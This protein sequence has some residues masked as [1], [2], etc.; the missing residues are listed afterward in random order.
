MT[1]KTMDLF[2]NA[3][4]IRLDI[5]CGENKQPGGFLGMDKLDLPGVDIVH[6]MET[7]PW[8]IPDNSV[9][10]AIASHV[11]EHID[12]AHGTFL[13][14]MDEVWRIL[15]PGC[16]FFF[17]V[18]Y[19]GSPG[20]W[21]DPTHCNG[22][23]ERTLWYFDPMAVGGA[24]YGFYRPK[25]WKIVQSNWVATGNLEA[26]FEKRPIDKSYGIKETK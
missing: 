19:A 8:P 25:P 11:L 7:F 24:L 2:D 26:V 23:T 12:P 9:N 3:K 22:I 15:K 5:G 18:P 10:S 20:Y 6:D 21:Q 17:A 1:K 16:H 14:F 13:K 4:G